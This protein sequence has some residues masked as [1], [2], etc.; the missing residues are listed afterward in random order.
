MTTK[1]VYLVGA[2]PGDPG[3]ITV[4][5]KW[6]IEQAEVIIYDYLAA[7]EL[8][9]YARQDAEIIYAGKQGGDHTLTQDQIN[10]LIA[11]KAK[12]GKTVTR[13]KGGDPF[14][15]GRG[16]EEIEVLIDAGIEFEIVPG[17]TSAIAAPAYAGIPLTHRKYTSSVTFVTGHEDPDKAESSLN[18]DTLAQNPGTLVFLMGVKNLPRIAGQLAAH[19]K[20]EQTPV[21]LVRWG[22]TP[23]QEVLSGTLADIA[24]K[25]AAANLKPPC[26]IIVGEVVRL[27]EKMKWFENRP[28]FGKRIAVTRARAQASEL[29][30][31]LRMLGASCLESP[32]IR[33]IPPDDRAPLIQA[34]NR[35]KEYD[36]LTFTS[37]NGV[38]SFFDALHE[39]GKDARALGHLQ[40]A[41]I[42]PS[43]AA[44]LRDYGLLSDI[45]PETFRAESVAAA[46]AEKPLSGRKILLARAKEA[47]SVLPEELVKMGADVDEVIAYQTVQD[48]TAKAQLLE[49]LEACRI[50]MVTFTSSSTVTNFKDLI[51]P[52]R[53]E[54]LMKDVAVA[55]IGPITSETAEKNGFQ[56]D[57]AAEQY[58]ISGLCE[59]IVR[60]YSPR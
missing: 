45:V 37:V 52:D 15:F 43:T 13:L 28:L 16:G 2:G 44:R 30:E 19:G 55:S 27:R 32:V 31:Q 40:T 17:V 10:A 3:L 36:W 18:W 24:E 48:S 25:A 50:D 23:D 26:I 51:P 5:G 34:V 60:Y 47:R 12:E 22:T 39:Q 53:F 14:I 54:T 6:C 46:F 41:C 4:K 21:A 42:G 59:A 35:I 20:D 33:I 57:T 9:A 11:R 8:L 56:V 29:V 7:D 38:E 49:E 1:K 58:T